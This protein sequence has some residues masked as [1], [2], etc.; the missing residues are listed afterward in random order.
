MWLTFKKFGLMAGS[1]LLVWAMTGC[2][3][4]SYPP[5]HPKFQE[6]LDSERLDRIFRQAVMDDKAVII[7]RLPDDWQGLVELHRINEKGESEPIAEAHKHY[8]KMFGEV[9]SGMSRKY[10]LS[11]VPPGEYYVSGTKKRF[12]T[13]VLREKPKNLLPQLPAG[14]VGKIHITSEIFK[15][16]YTH[17]TQVDV[18]DPVT[19]GYASNGYGL[20]PIREDQYVG[21]YNEPSIRY[22]EGVPSQFF[23]IEP[24]LKEGE[25]ITTMRVTARPRELLV[26]PD[27]RIEQDYGVNWIN[28]KC[29]EGHN[30]KSWVCPVYGLIYFY[31]SPDVDGFR[32][33]LKYH[34]LLGLWGSYVRPAIVEHHNNLKRLGTFTAKELDFNP[35]FDV[36]VLGSL[37]Q[38]YQFPGFVP[39]QIEKPSNNLS[40]PIGHSSRKTES[41]TN[42]KKLLKE[43]KSSK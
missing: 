20:I 16:P 39:D 38:P 27:L 22:K 26:M 2:G 11:I 28:N 5:G 19:V 1:A 3:A 41:E 18:Y 24:Q 35:P 33:S 37:H 4:I 23:W 43:K 34:W 10:V 6:E 32:A 31:R 8:L 40:G 14:A 42:K 12:L 9:S 15:Q 25:K 17:Y 21:S 13:S 36:Y 29:V 7:Q 30:S